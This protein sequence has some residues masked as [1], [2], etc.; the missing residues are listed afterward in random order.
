MNFLPKFN[1]TNSLQNKHPFVDDS[2]P[3]VPK[4]LFY[5]STEKKESR[6]TQWLR[7]HEIV[8][9]NDNRNIKWAVFRMPLPSDISQGKT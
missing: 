3:P 9:D 6:V 7:P 1:S 2:F 4:S 8:A 5:S